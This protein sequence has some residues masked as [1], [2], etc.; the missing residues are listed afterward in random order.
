MHMN[1]SWHLLPED[2][3]EFER[4]V[5]EVLH[6]AG[7]LPALD[8]L[9][10]RLTPRQLRTMALSASAAIA[11]CAAE[12]YELFVRLRAELREPA[13]APSS[14]GRSGQPYAE[15]PAGS[16]TRGAGA[17]TVSG[18]GAVSGS[19]SGSGAGEAAGRASGAGLV[20]MVSVLVPVLAGTA[21]V[22]F[23]LVGYLLH[24]VSPEPSIAAPMRG[25]GW[26][27]AALAAAAAIAAMAGLWLAAVRN[28][29][30]TPRVPARNAAGEE[31]PGLTERVALAR[32]AWRGAL[33]ERGIVPFLSEALADPDG[34]RQAPSS[35][36]PTPEGSASHSGERTPRLGYSGPRFSS[37]STS[38]GDAQEP[39][40]RPR[41]SSPDYSSPHYG[42]PEHQPE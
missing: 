9:G 21:A 40:P 17:G 12:E 19:G 28:G 13:N 10:D 24:V 2:R 20:A 6:N 18:S 38:D 27:F 35:Y 3:P 33:V 30:R 36:V 23:L 32:D 15:G 26:T 5:D 1:T 31:E 25:A 16:S 22:I 4:A 34:A 14:M 11:A 37:R 8:A 29:S 41:Y 7:R 42:G 39:G